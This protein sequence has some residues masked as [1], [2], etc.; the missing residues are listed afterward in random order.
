MYIYGEFFG[1]P[2]FNVEFKGHLEHGILGIAGPVIAGIHLPIHRFGEVQI[3]LLLCFAIGILHVLLGYIIGFRNEAI[4]HDL[5]HA[6]YA[7][8]SW[9][10][11]LIGGVSL[12]AKMMPAL[13]SK[14]PMPTGDTIFLLEQVCVIGIIL[15]IK[16]EGFISILNYQRF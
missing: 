15:L 6:I 9:M 4:E 3:L 13:M 12:I 8:G 2:I 16:G 1:F 5:K 11:I 14:S 10:M 7:K